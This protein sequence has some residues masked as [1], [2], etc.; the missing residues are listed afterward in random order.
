M[1]TTA[2]RDLDDSFRS[3]TGEVVYPESDGRP[4]AETDVHA[5]CIID[6]RTML[7]AH[8]ASEPDVYVSGNLLLYYEEGNPRESVAPDVFVVRGVRKGLHR[9]YRLWEEGVPPT[10]VLEVTSAGTRWEDQAAK[11]GL[12]QVLGVQE[13]VLFDPTDEYLRPPLQGYRLSQGVYQPLPVVERDAGLALTSEALGIEL[14]AGPQRLRLYDP[15]AGEYLRT[16]AEEA[17]ARRE[18]DVARQAAESRAQALEA[19]LA[20]LRD[21]LARRG[22]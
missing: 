6:V 20:R 1:A 13:Y 21:E 16:A 14:H 18:A 15:R 7:D 8:F 19:E 3:P 2:F 22:S 11:R 12:Y 9:T 10:F 5:R 4:M 17:A